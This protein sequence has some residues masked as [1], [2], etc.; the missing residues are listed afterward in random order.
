M[1]AR[2]PHC[3]LAELSLPP[4]RPLLTQHPPPAGNVLGMSAVTHTASGAEA[5][6]LTPVKGA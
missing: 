1:L 3:C 4:L 6:V 2:E 5:I